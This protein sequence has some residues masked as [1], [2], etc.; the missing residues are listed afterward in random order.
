MRRL[1]V[2]VL[3]LLSAFAGLVGAAR[4]YSA[5]E[6]T[7]APREL[8]LQQFAKNS[9]RLAAQHVDGR[10]TAVNSLQRVLQNAWDAASQP[11]GAASGWHTSEERAETSRSSSRV[12][13][14]YFVSVTDPAAVCNDGSPGAYHSEASA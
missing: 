1:V 8:R 5:S 13:S 3:L 12:M 6:A 10:N 7:A 14:R 2:L 4:T 11:I 9:S